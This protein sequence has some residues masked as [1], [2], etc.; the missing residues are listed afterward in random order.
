MTSIMVL[1]YILMRIYLKK[2]TSCF[3]LDFSIFCVNFGI[4]GIK[5]LWFRH[6][7]ASLRL[8]SVK[9]ICSA[10][11]Q[12]KQMFFCYSYITSYNHIQQNFYFL[13]K[14]GANVWW[15]FSSILGYTWLYRSKSC[16]LASQTKEKQKKMNRAKLNK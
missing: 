7:Y 6:F 5:P 11:L 8:C 13:I 14:N 16:I 12:Q 15:T 9:P 10:F 4:L 1:S 2:F 3:F